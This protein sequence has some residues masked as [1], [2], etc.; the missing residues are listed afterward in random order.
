MSTG[1][2]EAIEFG[3]AENLT[4]ESIVRWNLHSSS[5]LDQRDMQRVNELR[6]SAADQADQVIVSGQTKIISGCN[7]GDSLLVNRVPIG[8]GEYGTEVQWLSNSNSNSSETLVA[9]RGNPNTSLA[10]QCD[11]FNQGILVR[12]IKPGVEVVQATRGRWENP[13][14]N[15]SKTFDVLVKRGDSGAVQLRFI[16]SLPFE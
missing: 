9:L 11:P 14:N 10:M 13:E 15:L 1:S 4:T 16:P 2:G 7:P 3:G 12:T 8:D 5:S 6:M